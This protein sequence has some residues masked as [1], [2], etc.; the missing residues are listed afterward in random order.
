MNRPS[1]L[2]AV[3]TEIRKQRRGIAWLPI[4]SLI[5]AAVMVASGWYSYQ[6]FTEEFVQQGVTWVAIWSNAALLY[7]GL[8]MPILL[9]LHAAW[10]MRMEHALGNVARLRSTGL[11]SSALIPGKLGAGLVASAVTTGI[12]GIVYVIAGLLS[13]FQPDAELLRTLCYLALG[14][15]GGWS[16]SALML[17]FA[18]LVRS[19]AVT[20]GISVLVA[21]SGFGVIFVAPAL[22]WLWPPSQIGL[23]M[24][25]RDAM[26][27]DPIQTAIFLV[28]N[29]VIIAVCGMLSAWIIRKRES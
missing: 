1:I 23:G 16:T 9:G 26:T 24:H 5:L 20:V 3:S 21:V 28:I 7:G 11:V 18:S 8:V 25:A 6:S 27:L 14:C 12:V 4:A 10:E 15:V 19:F 13:G 17:V 22:Q 29:A 2:T